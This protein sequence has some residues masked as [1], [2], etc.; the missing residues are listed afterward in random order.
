[1]T[2]WIK[3]GVGILWEDGNV[4]KFCFSCSLWVCEFVAMV[5]TFLIF[6]KPVLG[7]CIIALVSFVSAGFHDF[8]KEFALNRGLNRAGV[9]STNP[10]DFSSWRSFNHPEDVQALCG[11]GF[12]KKTKSLILFKE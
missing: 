9:S 4:R 1:M 8:V 5:K 12:D 7:S 6:V 2:L 11:C 10:L 3:A